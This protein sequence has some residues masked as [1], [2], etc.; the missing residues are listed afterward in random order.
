MVTKSR[1]RLKL[2]AVSSG[3]GHWIQLM[4]VTP[5]FEG[6]DVVFVT[7]HESYRAQVPIISFMWSTTRAVGASVLWLNQHADSLGLCGKK[8]LILSFRLEPRQGV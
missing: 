3:G 6:C 7:V 1:D 2:L 5:G 8:D 4:R